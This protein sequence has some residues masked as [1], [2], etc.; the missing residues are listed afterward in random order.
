MDEVNSTRIVCPGL[1]RREDLG[2]QKDEGARGP[3]R[4]SGAT[5]TGLGEKSCANAQILQQRHQS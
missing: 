2:W 3:F 1:F 4:G 5:T